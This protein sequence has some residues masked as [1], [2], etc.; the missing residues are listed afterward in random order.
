MFRRLNKS[1]SVSSPSVFRKPALDFSLTGLVFIGMMLFMG[2]SAINSKANL[3]YAVF[4]LMIGVLVVSGFISRIVLRKLEVRRILPDYAIVGESAPIRYELHNRKRY[5]PS[6]SVTIS[7]LDSTQVFS[8]QPQAYMLHAAARRRALV[9]S[10]IVPLRRGLY[11]LDRLQLSTS[12]PFGFVRRAVDRRH[13]ESI[14][15]YP[16]IGEVD[17]RLLSMCLSAEQSGARMRP[18]RGG[19]DEFYGVKEYRQGENPRWIYWRRSARTG[20]LVSKEMTQVAPPRILIL[21]DTFLTD[22]SAKSRAQVERTIAMAASLI[23]RTIDQGLAV[24]LYVWSGDWTHVKPMRGKRHSHELL[25]LLA[26]LPVNTR[27]NRRELIS[28]GQSLIESTMTPIL[29]TPAVIEQNL[30]EQARGNW[31]VISVESEA[32]KNW[33]RFSPQI[34]FEKCAAEPA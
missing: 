9:P 23:S 22:S 33:F 17:P 30:S 12:F 7:E 29:M 20:T 31:L 34:D 3:L 27:H 2:L 24:G 26:R 32:A 28:Q 6:L 11:Q 1:Q 5:W 16:T 13:E 19:T 4:G 15:V 8:R 18:R 10:Q 21:L 25:T 14:L